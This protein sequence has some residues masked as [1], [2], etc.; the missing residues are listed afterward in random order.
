MTVITKD[1]VLAAATRHSRKHGTHQRAPNRGPALLVA[2]D[3]DEDIEAAA[4]KLHKY[5]SD[6]R[7]QQHT[8]AW[9]RVS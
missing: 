1:D 3:H 6:I 7:V 4:G 8:C 2:G 9:T 5:V